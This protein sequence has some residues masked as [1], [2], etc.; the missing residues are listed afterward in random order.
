MDIGVLSQFWTLVL[1]GFG[2]VGHIGAGGHWIGMEHFE[3]FWGCPRWVIFSGAKTSL[4]MTDV[5]SRRI[6]FK[7]LA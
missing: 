2:L 3:C 4:F 7:K 5:Y 1:G 6:L